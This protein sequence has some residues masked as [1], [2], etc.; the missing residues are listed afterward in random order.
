MP[1]VSSVTVERP[2]SS[3][4]VAVIGKESVGKSQL[5]GSLT[6]ARPVTARLR[7][8]TVACE[9]YRGGARTFVDTPGILRG[10][11]SLTSRLALAEL[12]G[13]DL[14]LLV[15]SG[16]HLDEDLADLLPL[17]RGKS[18]AVI[19]T[20]WDMAAAR[21]DARETLERLE[22]AVGV[23]LIAVDARALSPGDRERIDRALEA[24]RAFPSAPPAERAGWTIEP[25]RSPF[26]LPVVGPLLALVCL[27]APAWLAVWNANRLADALYDPVLG[28]LAPVLEA[29]RAW[30]APLAVILAG[31]YG[32]L[33]MGP[34]LLL[35][36]LPTVLVFALLLGVLKASGLIDRLTVALD[37][38]L[39]PFGLSGRD[40]VRVIMGF[41]CNVPAVINSRS[42]SACSRGACVSAISFGSACSYQLPA[43]LA[44]FAAAGMEGLAVVYLGLLAATTLVYLRLA[45]GRR[46]GR[47]GDRLKI[48]G[49]DFLQWPS[50]GAVWRDAWHVVRQFFSLALPVFFLICLSAALLDWAG[51]LP[52][53]ARALAPAMA[54]F[55]LP[56]EAALA[57]ILGS[58]RKDGIAIGLL[59]SSWTALK[60]PL[61]SPVQVLTAVYLAGVLLPCMVTLLTVVREM[62]A[63]FA[64]RMVG[65]QVLA[66]VAFSLLIAWGGALLF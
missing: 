63:G 26:E 19:V 23:A 24:P 6:G 49:R 25:R 11:D 56:G 61:T 45:A 52:W 17:V 22:A 53:L 20:F 15:V 40:L 58:V 57:V 46:A 30:P 50:P 18:G 33:S 29:V 27:F 47:P 28:R 5:V 54:P 48:V 1:L 35:Y 3:P 64:W 31:D 12:A 39:R 55:R 8:T 59:D 10:S 38:A 36:A 21:R 62:S 51:V 9:V 2:E 43:T 37:P 34:F 4:R 44:V 7:G 32:F 41:G 60:V 42:C 66:A 65:R 14:V 16:T 13:R